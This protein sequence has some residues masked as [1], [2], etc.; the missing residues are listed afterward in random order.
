[1][2][3]IRG[4]VARVE[5]RTILDGLDLVVPSGELHAVMGPNGGGKSTLARAIAGH[6]AVEVSGSIR[7]NGDE[8]VGLAPEERAWKGVFLGFQAPVEIPGVPNSTFL[9][10]AYNAQRRARGEP[11]VDAMDFLVRMR[12]AAAAVGVPEALIHRSVNE[13]FSGGER[14]RNEVL[15]YAL[16]DPNLAVFDELDS[17]LDVDA[18][19]AL[20]GVVRASLRPD[21]SV[22]VITH[23]T[24]LLDALEPH[25]VHVLAGGRIAESGTREL[26][27]RVE[28]SG[29]AGVGA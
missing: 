18:L 9:K 20:A 11:E 25:R 8:L 2:L 4:L 24:R 14:K 23:Y 1:M 10:A 28:A 5:G 16:L 29:Y 7:W 26:A 15:Q 22:L 13:G 21:R 27:E 3:E 6:P 12:R 17:G 19:R